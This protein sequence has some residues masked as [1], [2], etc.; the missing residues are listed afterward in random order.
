MKQHLLASIRYAA[1]CAVLLGA[2]GAAQAQGNE[3]TQQTAMLVGQQI[4]AQGNAALH[5]IR[6]ELRSELHGQIAPLPPL[7]ERPVSVADHAGGADTKSVAS[8]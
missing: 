4:A 1:I 5:E 6:Q 8:L 7:M 3:M 2:T